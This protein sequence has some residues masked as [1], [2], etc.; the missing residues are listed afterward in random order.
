MCHIIFDRI[1]M[2]STFFNY[3]INDGC[4]AILNHCCSV[5]SG[6]INKK[7]ELRAYVTQ[8]NSPAAL[9]RKKAHTCLYPDPDA[10]IYDWFVCTMATKKPVSGL[11]IFAQVEKMGADNGSPFTTSQGLLK[12]SK[13]SHGIQ[14]V[15]MNGEDSSVNVAAAT[16]FLPTYRAADYNDDQIYKFDDSRLYYRILP[17]RTLA[18]EN[19]MDKSVCFTVL[20]DRVTLLLTCNHSGSH[21]MKPLLTGKYSKLTCFH[22]MNME[23]LPI[24]YRHP[25]NA[26][27]TATLFE[28]WF[29]KDFVASVSNHL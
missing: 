29:V 27:M 6:C 12:R 15:K 17:D 16:E 7:D 4:H 14:G 2:V 9:V 10:A 5:L 1:K 26:W 3:R 23:K 18:Q 28:E 21:K 13:K 20:K 24:T 11:I 22:Y 8:S 19:E 25:W